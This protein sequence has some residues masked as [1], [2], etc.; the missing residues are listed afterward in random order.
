MNANAN[1]RELL[2]LD[3]RPSVNAKLN[4]AKGGGFEDNCATASLTFLNIH[5]IH[6]VRDSLKRM[7]AALIPR[8]DEKNYY[9]ALDEC[10]WLNH[11]QSILEGAAKA[12]FNVETEKQSVL[13]HC[14]DGWD[15]TA[16]LT[17]L[18]MIQL[19][20]YYRT[21]DGF[22]VL[23]EKEWCSFGHKFGERIGLLS[24]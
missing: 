15:R 1:C 2:I 17:S 4:R 14:S 12:V 24:L 8:V 3:A 11:I 13:I 20:P 23:I 5:N 22:I 18:T 7:V 9:K 16:Q 21:I 10:K 19:D 6:V